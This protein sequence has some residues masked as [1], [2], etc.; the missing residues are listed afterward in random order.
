[1]KKLTFLMALLMLAST[2]SCGGAADPGTSTTE[3][4]SDSTTAEPVSTE[5]HDDL[6]EFDFKED[7]FDILTRTQ[8]V[9]FYKL[10][11]DEETGDIFN[12]SIYKRNRAIE[13]RFNFRFAESYG[14]NDGAARTYILAG[15][16]TY[17][18]YQGRCTS[19]FTFAAE[20]LFIPVDKI[21]NLALSKPYWDQKLY[22]DLSV[23]GAHHFAVGAFNISS[24]DFTHVMLFNKKMLDEYKLG[25]IY[26]VVKSGKWTF[27]KFAE[28]GRK[29]VSDLNGDSVMDDQDQYGYT[30]LGKQVLPTFWISA[31]TLSITKN[32]DG[33]LVFSCPGDTKFIDV[34]EKI[35][36]ITWDD[37]I[38]HRVPASVNREEEI[39]LFRQGH[40]LFTDATCFQISN[41]RESN[42]DFGIVPYPKWDEAQDKY[43]SRIEGCELFGIPKINKK[44]EMAGV[45]LEAMSCESMKSVIPAYYDVALKV[46]Y[47]RDDDSADMLD[48]AFENR[49]FDYGDTV[50]CEELRDGFFRI[51]M[52]ENNRNMASGLAESANKVNSKLETFN[53]QLKSEAG[54]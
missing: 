6:G 52:A 39:E 47:T 2:V 12:D 31:N 32:K 30:S 21:P 3:A 22:D 17:D 26:D 10:D 49:V 54:K 23:C 9:F 19:M 45:I 14:N 24:Y 40:A 41:S 34:Y 42:V 18:M 36:Q 7:A 16:D 46:K 8:L 51:A 4:S 27:D 20:G 5:I 44:P 53:A 25:D 1:M 48:L 38:W 29:V 11:V 15:D 37:N 28:M 50:L 13:E 43:Y 33:E 35:F